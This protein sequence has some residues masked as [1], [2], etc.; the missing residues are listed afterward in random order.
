MQQTREKGR[1]R[2]KEHKTQQNVGPYNTRNE[3]ESATVQWIAIHALFSFEPEILP[4]KQKWDLQCMSH[5][6]ISVLDFFSNAI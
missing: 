5:G 6:S 3:N 2:R 4:N 1:K